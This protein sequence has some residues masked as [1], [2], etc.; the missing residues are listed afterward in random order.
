MPFSKNNN[1]FSRFISNL[2]ILTFT[3]LLLT[4]LIAI[5]F[6]I[7][8]RLGMYLW[9]L[10]W[11]CLIVFT[12][13]SSWQYLIR[14]TLGKKIIF[15][16][17]IILLVLINLFYNIYTFPGLDKESTQEISQT[18]MRFSDSVDAGFRQTTFLGYPT[19]QFYFPSLFSLV[20]K[21]LPLLRLGNS[22]YFILGM[23]IFSSGVLRLY[24]FRRSGD[25]LCSIL[26]IFP[27][28]SY[29]FNF[30]YFRF[31]QAF[32]PFGLG[33]IAV[34]LFLHYLSK[35]EK[36][37]ISLIALVNLFLVSSYITALALF[38]LAIVAQIGLL[39]FHRVPKKQKKELTII[40]LFSLLSFALSFFYRQDVRIINDKS[41]AV[42][43]LLK[44]LLQAFQLIIFSP[45]NAYI[46]PFANLPFLFI[47]VY[48]LF[49]G[50]PSAIIVFWII[51]VFIFSIVSYGYA[52]Y[53][54]HYRLYRF[55]ITFPIIF[56]LFAIKLKDFL[57]H[58]KQ[59]TV[60]PLLIILTLFL[61]AGFYY[62][63][64]YRQSQ[65]ISQ[66]Y[67]LVKFMGNNEKLKK[68]LSK[69]QTAYFFGLCGQDF[70]S[71]DD[72]FRYFYPQVEANNITESYSN[73]SSLPRGLLFISDNDN[74]YTYFQQQTSITPLAYYNYEEDKSKH[75]LIVLNQ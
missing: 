28:H 18:L 41:P 10:S 34:G 6:P 48:S 55:T 59:K 3:L 51:S 60:L 26:L 68:E 9:F 73:C 24:K 30:L 19:R 2:S 58:N 4:E 22:F 53:G 12:A 65:P 63:R 33:M 52:F 25:L 75:L 47:L 38:C 46:S 54:V 27:F 21:S 23:I 44:Q 71:I 66:D 35:P 32:Y 15:T 7:F 43:D 39:L 17:V 16:P 64:S 8:G 11:F 1:Q 14:K 50:W 56:A 13:Q 37:I 29:H 72:A 31:E 57:K 5:K 42:V 62:Q 49:S 20:N 40:I 61:S 69:T 67:L 70:L 45:E 74:C 36:Y